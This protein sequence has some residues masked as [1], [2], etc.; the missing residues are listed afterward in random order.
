MK[1]SNLRK[2][3]RGD[4]AMLIADVQCTTR[5]GREH[6]AP[7]DT[8]WV[9]VPREYEAGLTDGRC[10]G[11]LV[12]LLF[13]A[14][15]YGEDIEIDAAVSKRLLWNVNTFVQDILLAYD[16]SLRR[17]S[18][19]A[20]SVASDVPSG[21]TRVGTGF[22]G[23]VDSFSTCYAH[24]ER[25]RDSDY[26]IDT[27]VFLNVGSHGR[28][29]NERTVD[30]FQRRYAFLKEYADTVGLPFIPVD[31]NIHH[32]HDEYGHLRTVTL[33]LVAGVLATGNLFKRYYVASAGY[34]YRQWI[35]EAPRQRAYSTAGCC[36]PYLLPLLS[37]E[38]TEFVLD[39]IQ[40]SRAH[41]TLNI[42][43]YALTRQFLNVCLKYEPQKKNCGRCSKCKRIG[44]TLSA[45]GKLEE[46][47]DVFEIGAFR[48]REYVHMCRA[49]FDYGSDPFARDIV[50]FARSRGKKYP[51]RLVAAV[52]SFFRA[53]SHAFAKL[54]LR[55][56][57]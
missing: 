51:N 45:V 57:E 46:Y 5:C 49:V 42:T 13:P 54:R 34:S 3:I 41:K 31:S 32:W 37:T 50:D 6:F 40:W 43:D 39:G 2:E 38:T 8:I 47:A 35:D 55:S 27:L 11:F 12:A 9:S 44:L 56:P 16:D 22:S 26:K 30:L 21:A 7:N 18:V 28:V 14:M 52:V 36:E 53:P 10:D 20:T 25:E 23:G 24:Y 19:T 1:L 33:T 4:Q 15:A 17:I 48:R 29:G